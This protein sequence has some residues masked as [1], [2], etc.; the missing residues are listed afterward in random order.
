M[1]GYGAWHIA[2]N[3]PDT[4]AALGVHAGALGY[5]SSAEVTREA[6][7]TLKDLPTYFV[8]GTNDGLLSINQTAYALLE[9]AGNT[10]IEFVTF[11]GGHEYLEENV[12][13]MYLWMKEYVNDNIDAIDMSAKPENSHLI[14]LRSVPNPFIDVT[15]LC[16]T[17]EYADHVTIKIVSHDG[18]I[19]DVISCGHLEAGYHEFVWHA[20]SIPTGIYLCRITGDNFRQA[21]K[22]MIR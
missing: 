22:L 17:L 18:Q 8:C 10:D 13:A 1:G 19:Q 15:R 16:F 2:L 12:L 14:N 6:A 7:Q 9:E 21:I 11:V 5:N 3:S 4:W 20:E